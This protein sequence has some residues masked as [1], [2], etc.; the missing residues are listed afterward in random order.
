MPPPVKTLGNVLVGRSNMYLAAVGTAAP[1]DTLAFDE[2]WLSPWFH[3]GYTDDGL[4]LQIDKKEKRH[5]VD[6]ISTPA[7]ITVEETTMKV[8]ITSVAVTEMLPVAVA[9]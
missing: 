3:P 4:T 1:A 7:V 5:R 6:D 2:A 9:P 8:M